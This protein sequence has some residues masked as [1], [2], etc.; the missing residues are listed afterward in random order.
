MVD[1][2]DGHHLAHQLL[3]FRRDREIGKARGKAGDAQ[4]AHRVFD[5]GRTDVAQYLGRNIGDAV[6]GIGQ[7][8]IV[9]ARDGVDR[10]VTPR[11]IIG[12]ADVR[13][14]VEGKALVAV[15]GLALGA[16][17]RVFLVRLWVQENREVLADRLETLG[18]HGFGR[19]ADDD[20]ITILHRQ[21]EQFVAHGATDCVDLH[22]DGRHQR[23]GK[24]AIR[25]P[26]RP[27][28]PRAIPASPARRAWHR[29]TCATRQATRLRK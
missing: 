15:P 20:E 21:A 7:R 22:V 8:A 23:N 19:C 10:Q 17:E 9:G 26:F 12:K 18:Q 1:L 11:E 2:A 29:P 16:G 25:R 27:V 6:E 24:T 28:H 13:S 14:S 3:R 5:K 4:D